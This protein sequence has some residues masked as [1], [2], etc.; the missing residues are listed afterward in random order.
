MTTIEVI[1]TTQLD[2]DRI[3]KLNS[4]YLKSGNYA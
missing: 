2:V 3:Y 4:K 1:M